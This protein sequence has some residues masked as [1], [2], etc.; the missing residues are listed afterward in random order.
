M[1]RELLVYVTCALFSIAIKTNER[2]HTS[3]NEFHGTEENKIAEKHLQHSSRKTF[4]TVHYN[5]V[6]YNFIVLLGK[7]IEQQQELS[8]TS[9]SKYIPEIIQMF[10]VM[11]CGK[12][13]HAEY[14]TPF[15]HPDTTKVARHYSGGHL[16]KE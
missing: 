11:G 6:K 12:S 5:I 7:F 13:T 15:S 16:H 9:N 3:E 1:S 14:S 10:T 4:R 2:R 8:K